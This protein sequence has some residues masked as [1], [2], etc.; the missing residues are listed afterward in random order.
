MRRE[1]HQACGQTAMCLTKIMVSPLGIP[2]QGTAWGHSRI[3]I[4]ADL[5]VGNKSFPNLELHTLKDFVRIVITK[6]GH[7]CSESVRPGPQ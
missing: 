6:N 3:F 7:F 5:D 2:S 1:P 4:L